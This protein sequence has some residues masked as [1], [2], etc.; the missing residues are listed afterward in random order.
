MLNEVTAKIK[1]ELRNALPWA[2][3]PDMNQNY[4]EEPRG[5][6]QAKTGF[7]IA[8]STTEQVSQIVAKATQSA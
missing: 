1:N 7:L 6:F 4:L 2:A 5:I 3:F 8:P